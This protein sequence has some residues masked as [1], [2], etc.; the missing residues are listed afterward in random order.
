MEGILSEG[1]LVVR[2]G[3]IPA[4]NRVIGR[5]TALI[6]SNLDRPLKSFN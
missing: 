2:A 5:A 1:K 6:D 4:S 3:L